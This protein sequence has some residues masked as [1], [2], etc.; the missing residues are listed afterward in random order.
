[1]PRLLITGVLLGFVSTHAVKPFIYESC[2]EKFRPKERRRSAYTPMC[3]GI[4]EGAGEAH[5]A[6]EEAAGEVHKAPPPPLHPPRGGW[7][8]G[9]EGHAIIEEQAERRW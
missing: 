2:P 1:L 8:A 7:R 4:E 5:K 6:I 3:V 9:A